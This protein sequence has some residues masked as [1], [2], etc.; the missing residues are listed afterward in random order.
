MK[1]TRR[2]FLHGGL[3]VVAFFIKI[4]IKKSSNKYLN[5]CLQKTQASASVGRPHAKKD[6]LI[7][8]LLIINF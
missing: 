3:S 6:L 2:A 5:P 1:E 7:I 4:K 8:H